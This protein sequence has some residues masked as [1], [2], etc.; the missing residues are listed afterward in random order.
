MLVNAMEVCGIEGIFRHTC[1]NVMNVLRNNNN[2][3]LAMLETF[4][5]TI[6]K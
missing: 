5:N 6:L 2:V 4:V 1:E 3:C